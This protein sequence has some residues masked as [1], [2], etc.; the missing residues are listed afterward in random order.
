[1]RYIET[2]AR[3]DMGCSTKKKKN[4]VYSQWILGKILYS[5]AS[6]LLVSHKSVR[7]WRHEILAIV[8][9][10]HGREG[11]VCL[12]GKAYCYV[13]NLGA[14]D[15]VLNRHS[16]LSR[17]TKSRPEK[18]KTMTLPPSDTAGWQDKT[19]NSFAAISMLCKR[20]HE[21]NQQQ[22]REGKC[23]RERRCLGKVLSRHDFQGK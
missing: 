8:L 15:R 4:Q 21:E 5:S 1:M 16:Y 10:F 18:R 20:L 14:V 19:R 2:C 13:S 17:S 7:H 3:W 22:I 6:H 23:C 11:C 12:E 9:W